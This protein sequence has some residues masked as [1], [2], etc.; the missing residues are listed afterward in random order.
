MIKLTPIKPKVNPLNANAVMRAVREEMLATGR[1][2]K[3][4]FERT[5]ANWETP[6]DFRVTAERDGVTISTESEI[7]GYVDDGTKPH[8]IAPKHAKRLRFSVGGFQPKTN[9]RV[10][11]SGQGRS[12]AVTVFRRIVHHPGTE[13]REFSKILQDKW[14]K[15]IGVRIGQAIGKVLDRGGD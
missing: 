15:Q 10:I 7:Y 6:V 3:K 11:G 9:P 13:A 12:G 1:D 8:D 2:V 14:Q 4:D 5:T